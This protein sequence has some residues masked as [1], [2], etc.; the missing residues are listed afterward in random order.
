MHNEQLKNLLITFPSST[1]KGITNKFLIN[2]STLKLIFTQVYYY[3][4]HLH[5]KN[6]NLV[7][8]INFCL[9]NIETSTNT[10]VGI[11]DISQT[12][13]FKQHSHENPQFDILTC[14][15]LTEPSPTIN[16]HNSLTSKIIHE[17]ILTTLENPSSHHDKYFQQLLDTPIHPCVCYHQN[18]FFLNKKNI[19]IHNS[20]IFFTCF[21]SRKK[22][23]IV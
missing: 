15:N 23:I 16:V 19:K 20:K 22:I 18:F 14:N 21:T 1:F 13:Y 12:R 17:N 9:N 5:K 3:L 7:K 4:C 11:N 8:N 2:N 6:V 10:N